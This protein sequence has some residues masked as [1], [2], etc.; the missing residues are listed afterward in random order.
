MTRKEELNLLLIGLDKAGKTT[1]LE[2]I[3]SLYSDAPGLDPHKITSTVGLNIGRV[4]FTPTTKLVLWDLGGALG[5]QKI[6]EKYY[7]DCHALAF[8]IDSTDP[9]RFEEA[10]NALD[11]ALGSR[12]T[13]G[14]PLL[15][16]ASKSDSADAHEAAELASN[17]GLTAVTSRPHKVLAVS[18]YTGQGIADALSW[19]VTTAQ[20]SNR[21]LLLRQRTRQ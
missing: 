6:W 9:A 19:L 17:L 3:K 13:F 5:L 7:A 11:R 8:V 21:K 18:S 15:V 10:K 14:A 12:D 20:K 4:N 2:K 16:L 1:V